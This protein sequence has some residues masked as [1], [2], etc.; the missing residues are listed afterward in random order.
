MIIYIEDAIF[1][2]LVINSVILILTLF[3]LRQKILFYKVLLSAVFGCIVSIV[4]TFFNFPQLLVILIKSV[5]GLIMSVITLNKTS[6]QT[7]FLFFVVFLSFTFLMGGFCFF[8]IYLFG[9]E[10]YSLSNMSYNLPINL[11]LIFVLLAVYVFFLIK[12]IQI[13]YKKQKIDCFYYQLEIFSNNKKIKLKAYLDTGNLIQD[14]LTG[15]PIIIIN[16]KTLTKIF[17]NKIS[18][19]DFLT[20]KL[21]HKIKGKYINVNS[22]NTTSKMFVFEPN[23]V[24]LK[25]KNGQVKNIK[26]LIGVSLM[27]FKTN[28]FE[29]LLTP[30]AI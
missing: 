27:D 30:L 26:V 4:L 25:Q 6:F 16:F 13:F 2:N 22:I 10:I 8:I 21:N 14:S 7:I 18:F 5:T 12:A 24:K 3:S 19:M 29:A 20:C 9:G 11:K 1:D 15:L 17:S 28:S 23:L